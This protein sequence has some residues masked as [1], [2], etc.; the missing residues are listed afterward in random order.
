MTRD[1]AVVTVTDDTFDELVLR[2]ARPVLLEFWA[3]W[4]GPC[5]QLAPV[6]EEIAREQ[7]DRL[8]VAKLNIDENPVTTTTQHVL[9][10]PT[11][12]L[13][14]NGTLTKSLVGTRPKHHLLQLLP[15]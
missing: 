6:L 11:L 4:C 14:A 3:P 1:P 5:R 13:Y 15:T 8:T 2:S 9:A 12:H 10:A 7:A